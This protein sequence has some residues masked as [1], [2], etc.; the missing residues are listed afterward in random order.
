VNSNRIHGND[1]RLGVLNRS[2]S[3]RGFGGYRS[4]VGIE[5]GRI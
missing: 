4:L 5:I 2:S 1:N 3:S